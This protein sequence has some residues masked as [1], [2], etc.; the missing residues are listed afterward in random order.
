MV[1]VKSLCLE[2][3]IERKLINVTI[4]PCTHNTQCIVEWNTG[5]TEPV[6]KRKLIVDEDLIYSNLPE[7]PKGFSY[8]VEQMTTTTWR[9]HLNHPR[10]YSYTTEQVQTVWG[11]VKKNGNVHRPRN[12]TKPSPEV[13]GKVLDMGSMNRYTTIK[14]TKESLIDL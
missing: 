9:V 3:E 13:V 6:P 12:F 11:F 7:P 10:V 2:K 1:W 14:P 5:I 8:G 4:R